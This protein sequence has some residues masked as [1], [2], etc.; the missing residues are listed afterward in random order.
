[1]WIDKNAEIFVWFGHLPANIHDSD[2][3]STVARPQALTT[4]RSRS[5]QGLPKF[6]GQGGRHLLVLVIVCLAWLLLSFRKPFL[7]VSSQSFSTRVLKTMLHIRVVRAANAFTA[8]GDTDNVDQGS[9]LIERCTDSSP[10]HAYMN[11]TVHS[12]GKH[13]F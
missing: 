13:V 1:M 10:E 12:Y 8:H 4:T 3:C 9:F 11:I 7:A 5:A 6:Q 2:P